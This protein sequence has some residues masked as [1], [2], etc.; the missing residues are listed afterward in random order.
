LCNWPSL[1]SEIIK[2]ELNVEIVD[3]SVLQIHRNLSARIMEI[4][5]PGCH[6]HSPPPPSGTPIEIII[7]IYLPCLMA[8]WLVILPLSSPI[9]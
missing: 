6:Y 3:E 5:R 4:T 8:S 7:Y 2:N 1:L 9:K